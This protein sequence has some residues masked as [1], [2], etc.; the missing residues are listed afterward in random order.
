M[1]SILHDKTK[2]TLIDKVNE[3]SPESLYKFDYLLKKKPALYMPKVILEQLCIFF[4]FELHKLVNI[5][6]IANKDFNKKDSYLLKLDALIDLYN[7]VYKKRGKEFSFNYLYEPKKE[8][9]LTNIPGFNSE[10]SMLNNGYNKKDS[11]ILFSGMINRES[12]HDPQEFGLQKYEGIVYL[13]DILN[14]S[15]LSYILVNEES[16][17]KNN[18]SCGHPSILYQASGTNEISRHK[19]FFPD[20]NRNSVKLFSFQFINHLKSKEKNKLPTFEW[21]ENTFEKETF[22]TK[23]EDIAKHPEIV[24][25]KSD[26][27][28]EIMN[29]PECRHYKKNMKDT[30]RNINTVYVS[31]DS[32]ND[33]VKRLDYQF[34]PSQIIKSNK[35]L[36]D[37]TNGAL[38]EMDI[39]KLD[40]ILFLNSEKKDIQIYDSNGILK[41][42][43]LRYT[44]E[45]KS[46]D[47][48]DKKYSVLQVYVHRDSSTSD[49]QKFEAIIFV[50][51]IEDE[52]KKDK[53]FKHKSKCF[54]FKIDELEKYE[55]KNKG[56]YRTELLT[57]GKKREHHIKAMKAHGI[58]AISL[59]ERIREILTENNY[60]T[61][62]EYAQIYNHL[63]KSSR[64]HN[65]PTNYNNN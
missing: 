18:L 19:W 10:F 6:D 34:E 58:T 41:L 30:I 52:N 61:A 59:M 48:N 11:I 8:E 46:E 64:K 63:K 54:I 57:F 47:N 55:N 3:N 9:S 17:D 20:K 21:I 25:D 50:K 7:Q 36:T 62:P 24:V 40:E 1:S 45:T 27:I 28:N 22:S 12:S 37:R 5:E 14:P 43:V 65:T 15:R 35:G 23:L 60:Q 29:R 26:K 51:N 2:K 4:N 56:L 31:M 16:R 32:I 39:G 44:K 13:I 42:S 38:V 53:S 49:K 33:L